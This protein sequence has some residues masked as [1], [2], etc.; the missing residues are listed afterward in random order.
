MNDNHHPTLA[1]LV[2]RYPAV[3][4]TFI[5][6]E[7]A[8]LRHLGFTLRVASVN[9]PDRPAEGWT[10]AEQAEAETT[11]YLKRQG[12]PGALIALAMTLA[13]QPAGLW[14]GVKLA[15]HLGGWDIRRI[16]R[17]FAY[18][19]GAAMLG[20]WMQT[21]GLRHLHVHSATPAA[22]V[23]LLVKAVFGTGY[24]FTAHG[25]DEFH[26]AHALADPIHGADFVACTSHYARGQI[27][28]LSPVAEWPK[29]EVCRLGVDPERF[30]PVARPARPEPFRLLCVGRL[31]PA[32]GQHVLLD[33]LALLA[34]RGRHPHLTLVGDGP[35][36]ASL[37]NHAQHLR[38]KDSVRFAG[39][40]NQEV[41]LG[42]YERADAFVLPS[43][44]EGL[45]V[46]LME[47]LATGLAC[48]ATRIGGVPELID[49]G[50]HGLLV[51]ASDSEGL[52]DAIERLMD[53]PGLR[54]RL[55]EAG[56]ARVLADYV[57]RV[58]SARLGAIFKARLGGD[59]AG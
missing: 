50:E 58:N 49:D 14:R 57:L 42:L 31:V 38:L 7:V 6:R 53:D 24:S 34:R 47:A 9:D 48:V 12:I 28:K 22:A 40:V 23:G 46:T 16:A 35:D 4:H 44:A 8:E 51:A 26:D 5:L 59:A 27:Q 32:K 13:K 43:F 21:Q 11:W 36:R 30:S 15:L 55:A 33:A 3:S 20:R 54:A 29:F 37:E 19:V 52:A 18:L 25:P 45:P 1:Y 56:R 39:A 17:N 2:G 41:V 10:E